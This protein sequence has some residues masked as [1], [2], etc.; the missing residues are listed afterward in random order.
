MFPWEVLPKHD[1]SIYIDA[2]IRILKNPA[3]IIDQ[4]VSDGLE[5]AI[6]QHPLRSNVWQEADACK[7]LGKIPLEDHATLDKQLLRYG[8]EG[9]P[10]ESGLTE[11][12]VIIRSGQSSH[13]TSVM[14]LW[15]EE[16]SRG[17]KRDQISL[18]YVL[19]KTRTSI[20]RIPFSARDNNHYFRIVT[21]RGKGGFSS[22]LNARCHHGSIWK[23][24]YLC[25]VFVSQLRYRV[26][27]FL[28]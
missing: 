10:P 13:L 4:L 1:W 25:K 19:W 17:V 8:S 9:L 3:E 12:N 23:G 2:N 28:Y 5:M 22:Y 16:F 18:P 7:R 15:W 20:Y 24:L 11:N 26:K 14:T 6:F 27:R 21:H